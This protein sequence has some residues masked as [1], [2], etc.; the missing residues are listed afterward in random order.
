[1][2]LNFNNLSANGYHSGSQIARILTEKWV[3]DNMF[4]PRCGS[5]HINRFPNNRPVADFYCP[6]CNNE[7]ELKSKSGKIAH[8]IN[9]GAYQTMIQ[10]ITSNENPDFFFMSYSKEFLCVR[11]FVFVPKH[12][13]VPEIIERRNP[14][15]ESARRAGWV[16][17]NI[18][19]DK[20]PEQGRIE[21]VSNGVIHSVKTVVDR[22]DKSSRL[23]IK[24][25]DSRGWLLD[26]LNCINQ[27]ATE[28]FS[29]KEIYA[30]DI[31]LSL[32]HPQNHN[33]RAKIR[34]Q[35]QILRDKGF[36]K[37]LGNGVYKKI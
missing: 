26:I 8:K 6:E 11:D 19:L 34:Q 33:I 13:F 32:K 20:I 12:F 24:D 22:V 9:D 5:L 30:F 17:C 23:E 2:I 18:L 14:L 28:I 27:I 3:E 21:I 35:L 1:M 31:P 29:L 25:I 16:G 37:F 7:Y 10:R 15:T 36:I 4:C